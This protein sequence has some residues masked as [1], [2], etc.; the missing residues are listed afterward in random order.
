MKK[1]TK[2]LSVFLAVVM[3]AS[4]FAVGASAA[5]TNK[6]E[7]I[8]QSSGNTLLTGVVK[9]DYSASV[10]VP[11]GAVVDAGNLTLGLTM[12]DIASL[13]IEG[14]KT[15][16]KTILT[17]VEKE[18]ELDNYMPSF[19]EATVS[20][21]IDGVAYGYDLTGTDTEKAYSIEAVPQDEAAVRAAWAALTSHI[22]ASE[23]SADDSYAII[24]AGTWIQI[25]TEK[26]TFESEY[27]FD[28]LSD[29]G[30]ADA[31]RA[32][33]KLEAV[34]ELDDAQVRIF[35]P[36]GTVL[37]LSNT[38]ATLDDHA[39]I[40]LFGY[41]DSE[42][43]NTILSK[44]RDCENAEQVILTAVI[45]I[46]D[47]ALVVEGQDITVN[48]DF[49]HVCKDGETVVENNIEATCTKEGSYDNVVY[50]DGCGKEL[51][52]ETVTVDK[53]GHTAGIPKRENKIDE[54]C[55]VDGSYDRVVRC[56]VC[57]EIVSSE[58][59]TIP[60][61]G[62]TAGEEYEENRVEPDCTNEGSYEAV[63][64][65]TVCGEEVSR[66]TIAIDALGHTEDE[67]VVEN[68]VAP[69]C[70]NTGSYD[71]VVYCKVCD[72]E[73]LRTTVVVNALGHTEKTI[74]GKDSDC[75]NTGLTDGKECTVCGEIT[76]E[77][78]VIP[79][80][81]HTEGEAVE[82]NIVAAKCLETG[83]YDS[84]VYCV[85]CGKELSRETV[86]IPAK[87]HD[88]DKWTIS[89][90]ETC[91]EQGIKYRKCKACDAIETDTVNAIGH[92]FG[93]GV[94]T[95]PTCGQ[96]GCTTYTCKNCGLEEL[97]DIKPALEHVYG[98]WTVVTEATC[99]TDGE[100]VKVCANCAENAVGH[101]LTEVIPATGHDMKVKEVVAPTDDNGGYT[102]YEC[103]V[104]GYTEIGDEVPALPGRIVS[105]DLGED[106]VL[107]YNKIAELK[108]EY[109]FTKNDGVEKKSIEYKSA[110]EKVATVDENG[111]IVGKGMGETTITCTVTD[112]NGNTVTDEIAIQV[113]FSFADWLTV[114]AGVIKAAFEI[115][116]VGLFGGIG[117]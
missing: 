97:K 103:A 80:T 96:I 40:T 19:T 112:T 28:N 67:K 78:E 49:T 47:L 68:N 110:N 65:C 111:V 41:E 11:H 72:D 24:P 108:P 6:V 95:E 32:A 2:V 106:I 91:T 101:K 105:V 30:L 70:V 25:G 31:L 86:E 29:E 104:C 114:I 56:V 39:T 113:K 53:T 7:L 10:T 46:N 66:E 76:L 21:K 73:V 33:A 81:G 62:H 77:Q 99:T 4:M 20:G 44:L 79:A 55:T 8:A 75:E 57:D 83:S 26:L 88:F 23:Q 9:S 37:A 13:G 17:G 16:S 93:E 27:K 64:D 34:E 36:A 63:A 61:T 85:D 71:E 51:S 35:L 109:V 100:K 1:I 90:N 107:G 74:P 38:K 117:K 116:I 12:K 3:M 54:T 82:E 22:T 89:K 59:F 102:V 115:V 92:D 45:F 5:A 60:A 48:I 42:D 98:E 69:D 58:H 94:V 14:T 43:V 18:V 50:C 15:Y 52:R 84:V 87:G